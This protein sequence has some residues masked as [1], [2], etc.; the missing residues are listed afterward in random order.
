V[1]FSC[2]SVAICLLASSLI[3]SRPRTILPCP[4]I[5]VTLGAESSMFTLAAIS[6]LVM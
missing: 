5:E 3:A 1:T 2:G 4:V 6:V